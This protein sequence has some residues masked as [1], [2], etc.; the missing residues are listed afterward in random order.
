MTFSPLGRC[1]VCG[2]SIKVIACIVDALAIKKI[3]THLRAK[4]LYR[5]ATASLSRPA[6]ELVRRFAVSASRVK[7]ICL[8]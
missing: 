6:Y 2:G 4:V 7:P 5:E 3:L 1:R 8:P